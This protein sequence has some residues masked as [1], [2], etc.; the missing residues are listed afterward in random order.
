MWIGFNPRVHIAIADLRHRN[1]IAQNVIKKYHCAHWYTSYHHCAHCDLPRAVS[2]RRRATLPECQCMNGDHH[3]CILFSKIPANT[4]CNKKRV[5][6]HQWPAKIGDHQFGRPHAQMGT[7]NACNKAS[8]ACT[9][10][11]NVRIKLIAKNMH[12]GSPKTRQDNKTTAEIRVAI[13]TT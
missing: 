12:M 6:L 13:I 10:T 2:T 3:L 9:G 8:N 1:P 11:Y 7:S 4:F 5:S